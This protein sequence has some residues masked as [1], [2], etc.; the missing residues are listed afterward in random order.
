MREEVGC[1]NEVNTFMCPAPCT[2]TRL[3]RQMTKAYKTKTPSRPHTKLYQALPEVSR[4]ECK[5]HT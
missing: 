3:L 5:S 4:A 1:V 2:T